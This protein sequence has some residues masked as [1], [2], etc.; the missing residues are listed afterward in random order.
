L[1][2]VQLLFEAQ[3]HHCKRKEWRDEDRRDDKKNGSVVLS[4]ALMVVPVPQLALPST[5]EVGSLKFRRFQDRY[6]LHCTTTVTFLYVR[7][8]GIAIQRACE[9]R[10]ERKSRRG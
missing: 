3:W 8:L 9:A 2:A 4:S 10:M 1:T 6:V 7:A 5:R